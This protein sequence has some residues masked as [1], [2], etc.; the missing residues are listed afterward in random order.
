MGESAG[1]GYDSIMVSVQNIVSTL[2]IS[3][4]CLAKIQKKNNNNK[5]FNLKLFNINLK[6]NLINDKLPILKAVRAL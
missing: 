1:S 5:K 3:N 2:T 6:K 4:K